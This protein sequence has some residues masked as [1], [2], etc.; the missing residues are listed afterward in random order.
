MNKLYIRNRFLSLAGAAFVAA[1]AMAVPPIPGFVQVAQPDGTT[2]EARIIGDSEFHYY[3]LR[4]GSL[5]MADLADGFLKPTTA[6]NIEK[7]RVADAERRE[8]AMRKLQTRTQPGVIRNDFPTTGELKGIVVLAEFQ[9]VKFQPES[10]VEYFDKKLNQPGYVGPE[11]NG[12]AYDYFVEQSN[13]VFKPQFDVV[14]PVTLPKNRADYG[15]YEDLKSLFRD[16]ANLADTECNVNF[17]D[18]DIND[19]HYIDFFMVIFAGHGEAQGG[20]TET[21]WPAMKDMSY[22]LTENFDKKY[23]GQAACFCELKLGTGTA[24][25]GIGTICH[26]YSHILGLPD[27]Y[28]SGSTGLYGMGHYDLMCYGPYNDDSLTPAGYTAMDKYTLGWITPRVL[29]APEKD[30]KLGDL[31]STNECIFIVNP[32]NKDEYYT[33]ENRQPVGFDKG[34]PGHGLVISYVHYVRSNWNSNRV[35]TLFAGYE[36]VALIAADDNR[37]L[38]SA[39]TSTINFEAGDPFPGTENVTAFTDDTKPAAVWNSTGK[40]TP[41]GMPITNIRE[42]DGI[43]TFDFMVGESAVTEIEVAEGEKEYYSL[44]GIKVAAENL[45]NGIYIER[46]SKGQTR[47]V[48]IRR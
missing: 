38:N 39:T 37:T 36:H 30:V 28:D 17:A 6:A 12:S 15:Q 13:G 9:D 43:I 35:N 8:V 16:A 42:E 40:A 5:M 3:E 26:E 14:G 20:P 22:E 41:I 4:D 31:V 2:V 1:S 18:Y 33:L 10:T 29:E 27:I 7:L 19:D 48:S 21:V 11:T 44:Q 25:D 23:M 45:T 46:D 34:L 47:K 24:A 32:N